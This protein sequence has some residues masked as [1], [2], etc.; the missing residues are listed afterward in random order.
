M[1]GCLKSKQSLESVDSQRQQ[2]FSKKSPNWDVTFNQKATFGLHLYTSIYYNR[3]W[4]SI[5]HVQTIQ[6][7]I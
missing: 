3:L 2:H 7:Q 5:K 6:R 4:V 1:R